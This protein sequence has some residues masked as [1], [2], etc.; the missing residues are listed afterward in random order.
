MGNKKNTSRSRLDR[1]KEENQKRK[2]ET[3]EKYLGSREG[4]DTHAFVSMKYFSNT[5]ECISD[6]TKQ[7]TKKFSEFLVR[8]REYTWSQIF[9]SGGASGTKT[10]WGYTP[11]SDETRKKILTKILT[12]DQSKISEDIDSFFELRVSDEARVHGFRVNEAFFLL[13]LDKDHTI[14]RV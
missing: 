8:I 4:N 10:G 14:C 13:I 5:C 6:W 2:T 9:A 7:D 3:I 1:V 12:R 11:H